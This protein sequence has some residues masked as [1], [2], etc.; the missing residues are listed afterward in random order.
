M[1]ARA[2]GFKSLPRYHPPQPLEGSD[3]RSARHL[4]PRWRNWYTRTFEGRMRQLIRVQVPAWAPLLPDRPIARCRRAVAHARSSALAPCSLRL[5]L[6]HLAERPIARARC[7]ARLAPCARPPERRDFRSR[8]ATCVGPRCA[9]RRG[10]ESRH[11]AYAPRGRLAQPG[12][13]A[14]LTPRK[15]LVRVQYRPPPLDSPPLHGRRCRRRRSGALLDWIR[16][17]TSPGEPGRP[18]RLWGETRTWNGSSSSR[19]SS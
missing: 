7:G 14:S 18:H 3:R 12:Q 4:M 6:G 16:A 1:S 2:Y 8:L 13:S 9:E 19:S 17:Q 15:S 11:R 10:F 5:A